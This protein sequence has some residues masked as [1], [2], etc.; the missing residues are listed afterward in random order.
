MIKVLQFGEGNFLR[1]FAEDYFNIA[2]EKGILDV[3]VTICQPRTNTA[4]INKLNSQNCEY[5]V[6][7]RGR[8]NGDVVDETTRITCVK[9]CV[10]T[11]GEYDKLKE[12][13]VNADVIISNTTEAGIVF[14][15][16]DKMS[17][18][19]SVSFPAK[20]TALLY[21]R[22]N[23]NGG[24]LLFLPV[25]LIE[26]NADEL[27]KCVKRYAEL[28][29]LGDAFMSYVD[30]CSFCNTLVDR[31]VSGH[32]E[33]D[34]DVCSVNCEPYASWI[35]QAD[36]YC[37][38]LLPID[39]LEGIV[40][41]T[42]IIPYRTRKVRILNGAHTMSVLAARLCGF[43]IVRD[44]MNDELFHTYIIRGLDEIKTTLNMDKAELDAYANSVLDRFNNPF[45]DHKL[46]DISL[47]SVSKFKA[48]CMDSLAEYT[49]NNGEAPNILC[50]ALSALIAFYMNGEGVRDTEDVLSFFEGLKNDEPQTI[51]S[52]VCDYYEINDIDVRNKVLYHYNNIVSLGIEN[53]VRKAVYSAKFIRINEADNVA[54]ATEDIKKGYTENGVTALEDIPKAHKILLCDLKEGDNVVK[55]GCP[56]GHITEDTPKGSYIHEHNLKTNL[57]DII[58]YKFNCDTEY[59]PHGSDLTINAYKR[60]NGKIGVRNEIWII[61]TVGC[62]N[63]AAD[64]LAK[65]GNE[66]IGEGCDGVFAYTHPY[67]CSQLDE[68]QENTRKILAA[69]VN[70]PNAGG[71]LVLSLGCENTNIANFKPYL[72]EIDND[73]V[74]FLCAQDVEDELEAGA[75]LIKELY[76]NIKDFKREPV[77]FDNLIIGYKC[78]GSDAFSGITAN[79]LCGRIN[80]RLTDAGASTILTEVPEMFGAEQ[81]LM[82]RS[83]NREV[84]DKSVKMINDFKEYFYSNGKE[85]YENPSPGNHDG[86][87]TTLEEKSLGC[88]QKGGKSTVTD[89]LTYGDY[90]TKKGLNLLSGPGND[91]VSITNLTAA[92]AH[93]IFFTTGRGTSLGAPVPTIKVSS[94]TA[95]YNKKRNWIDFNAGELIGNADFD[96][97]TD[98]LMSL[99][100]DVANGKKTKNEE[101]GYKEISIFKN[102][103]I[104]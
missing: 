68:D 3:E 43:D 27:K 30:S 73:R 104:M 22:F 69:L 34:A 92:G 4:V 74:K 31:I 66:I 47:N 19:P 40:F 64:R 85:C 71:V 77:G 97:L 38:E 84:F 78:G 82:A 20:I 60:K 98:D 46:L 45:I 37:K 94:N 15:P 1:A 88:I 10:D 33:G 95:L 41:A 76:N 75:E 93:I 5:N 2:N 57:K 67:G 44:M 8:L 91:I 48:R 87:I 18:S 99:L 29:S 61:P 80:E 23:Q 81:L 90:C 7:K 102:G 51:V 17:D 21:E 101:N 12:V 70:H 54:V 62:I 56:I 89:V 16:D 53:A 9:E 52:K 86:G 28:W 39:S 25:E 14:N 6:Y 59:E 24:K 83:Q 65:I 63:K 72:G 26:N 58:D 100:I 11:V 36:D 35:I 32:T 13:F 79:A 50:F 55:Y 96:S 103:V 49:E 42:D